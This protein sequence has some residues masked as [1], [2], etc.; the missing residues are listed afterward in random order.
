MGWIKVLVRISARG[1]SLQKREIVS[2]LYWATLIKGFPYWGDLEEEL[3]R[4]LGSGVL[5]VA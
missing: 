1:F 2:D 4:A 3:Q 5:I